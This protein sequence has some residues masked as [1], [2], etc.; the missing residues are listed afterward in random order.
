MENTVAHAMVEVTIL[1]VGLDLPDYY[2]DSGRSFD[3][4]AKT[5][6]IS[7]GRFDIDIVVYY[8]NL[9]CANQ[10]K[11]SKCRKMYSR[12]HNFPT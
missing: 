5:N 4:F 11:T 10:M 8:L 9:T 7:I 6:W 3:Y 1:L 2:M 12:A